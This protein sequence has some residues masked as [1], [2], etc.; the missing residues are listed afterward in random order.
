MEM[1]PCHKLP[2]TFA[3]GTVSDK[4]WQDVTSW[5][6]HY[7][8]T[9]HDVSGAITSLF[10]TLLE[11]QLVTTSIDKP[12]ALTDFHWV[13][14]LQCSHD[15]VTFKTALSYTF[16]SSDDIYIYIMIDHRSWHRSKPRELS[17]SS[18]AVQS[19]LFLLL[20]PWRLTAAYMSM[21]CQCDYP[22]LSKYCQI[23]LLNIA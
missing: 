17:F 5:I 20:M 12:L 16:G 19:A 1:L 6:C 22:K 18:V 23:Y 9:Y 3:N 7:V 8:F 21:W 13:S 15:A 4:K 10:F 14:A 2:E 11:D